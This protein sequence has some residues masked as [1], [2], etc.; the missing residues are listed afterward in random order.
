MLSIGDIFQIQ[1]YKQAEHKKVEKTYQTNSNHKKAG[2]HT[3]IR[4]NGL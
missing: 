3:N 1:R 4:Q 2:W